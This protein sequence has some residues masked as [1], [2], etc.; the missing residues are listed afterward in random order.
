[1]TRL[2][3]C[4]LLFVAAAAIDTPRANQQQ[5]G[6]ADAAVELKLKVETAT[7]LTC[8]GDGA[9]GTM[10]SYLSKGGYTTGYQGCPNGKNSECGKG[11]ICE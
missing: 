5:L 2:L 11:G 1:M 9:G 7:T 3:A 8:E 10:S 6:A 4:A